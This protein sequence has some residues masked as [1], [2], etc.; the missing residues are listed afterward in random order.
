MRDAKLMVSAI[1]HSAGER[2]AQ[3]ERL[4]LGG[5]VIARPAA[6]GA[7]FRADHRARQLRLSTSALN[8]RSRPGAVGRGQGWKPTFVECQRPAAK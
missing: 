1:P 8:W 4:L 3:D 7:D 6:P 2:N 5:S